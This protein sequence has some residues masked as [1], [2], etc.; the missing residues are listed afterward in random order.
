M[1]GDAGGSRHEIVDKLPIFSVTDTLP[2]A[3][4][5]LDCAVTRARV[6]L[7]ARCFPFDAGT[8]ELVINSTDAVYVVAG[9]IIIHGRCFARR[10]G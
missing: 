7:L 1:V 5:S 3:D 8:A 10:R 4:A 2:A 6:E 9:Q